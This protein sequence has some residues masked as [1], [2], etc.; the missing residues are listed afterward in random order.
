[1]NGVFVSVIVMTYNTNLEQLDLC[2]SSIADQSVSK[3]DYEILIIDNN[4]NRLV[5]DA[6]KSFG[7]I[8]ENC[9]I[10]FKEENKGIYDSRNL[11]IQ[12]ASG[13]YIC[14]IDSDDYIPNDY[15]EILISYAKSSAEKIIMCNPRVFTKCIPNQCIP[16]SSINLV[17]DRQQSLY[18]LLTEK[19][20][21]SLWGKLI[22]I[23][24]FHGF[25]FSA[26]NG[27][28]DCQALPSV[29]NKSEGILLT[30]QTFYGWR[31]S[32]NGSTM[33]SYSFLKNVG[34]SFSLWMDFALIHCT[35]AINYLVWRKL[36]HEVKCLA[37]D[38]DNNQYKV[39]RKASRD[40]RKKISSFRYRFFIKFKISKKSMMIHY[41]ITYFP[42]LFF[43]L[44]RFHRHNTHNSA[45]K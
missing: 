13:K 20:Y 23:D 2:L 43:I 21:P 24:C 9:T 6:L 14:Y 8:M 19:L 7:S 27:A 26:L 29:I 16:R 42:F 36:I 38:P 5:Q 39:F 28:D 12:K 25:T 35:Q 11:S 37:A 1:M 41:L 18:C 17:Y 32:P 15:L 3:K 40:A 45:Q 22:P 10:I 44:Y 33:R 34:I 30:N 31:Q 4:S